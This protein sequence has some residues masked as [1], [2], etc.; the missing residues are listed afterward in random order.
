LSVRFPFDRQFQIGILGLCL[1]RLEFLLLASEV[2]KPE[3][4][5]D[6]ILI[7]YFEKIISYYNQYGSLPNAD[8]LKNELKKAARA[9]TIQS[10]E[11]R[12]YIEVLGLLVQRVSAAAYVTDEVV[13]FCRRQEG[14]K[15]YLDTAEIMDTATDDDWDMILERLY[16]VKSIGTS[17][18]DMGIKYFEEAEARVERR[19]AGDLRA[20]APTGIRG[21]HKNTHAP[22]DLDQFLGGGL[23]T[24]QLGIWMGATNLGKSIALPHCGKRAV[25]Q[26]MKV[27]HVTLE[28]S[29]SDVA[30]RY[31][32]AWTRTNIQELV[33]HGS[34]VSDRLKALSDRSGYAESLIIKE[35]P[36]GQASV[37]TLR[38]QL[39]QLEAMGWLPDLL[40]VDYLDLLKPLTNYNDEYADLGHI[41]QDLR[42]L[43]G[44]FE[45]PAWSATQ[46]NR[47]GMSQET[48]DIEHMGDSIKKAQ[49]ADVILV[50]CATKEE[51]AQNLLRIFIAKN[52]NG[53]NKVEL[54]IR[55]AYHRMALWDSA[56]EPI[57]I[58]EPPPE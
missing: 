48:P 44:E 4:F 52:R 26:G 18:L 50:M 11:V 34:A 55:T 42:G 35:Y 21:W 9:K 7:W 17:Q 12:D 57:D 43:C 38:G 6:K 27:L 46:T 37:N 54:E 19:A 22:M 20:V 40:V 16:N 14:R 24:G 53:P 13:R 32:S 15:I 29:A 5:E 47:A 49:I 1:Q 56:G 2:I 39:R 3:Y 45:I 58:A 30:D 23:K 28:L 51:R 31:D 33:T 41:A 36:T 10:A 25:V 8:V